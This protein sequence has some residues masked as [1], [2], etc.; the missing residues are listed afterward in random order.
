[1][2]K[3]IHLVTT[4]SPSTAPLVLRLTLAL[5]FFPHGAQFVGYFGGHSFQE[6]LTSFT[7]SM[8]IPYLCALAAIA[9]MILAPAALLAGFFTRIAALALAIEMTVA[10]ISVHLSNGFFMNWSGT[11]AGEGFE[12]HLLAVGICLALMI[13]GSGSFSLDRWMATQSQ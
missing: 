7:Q 11:Q 12:Y 3:L 8:G 10:I 13:T 2:K 5:V 9:T 4:T 1:M 6:T